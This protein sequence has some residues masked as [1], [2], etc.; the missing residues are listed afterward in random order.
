MIKTDTKKRDVQASVT[1]RRGANTLSAKAT[2]SQ[3]LRN[4]GML[5]QV[6][7]SE[8]VFFLETQHSCKNYIAL[9]TQK[10]TKGKTHVQLTLAANNK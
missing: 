3:S 4:K 8:S 9:D 2:V 1:K 6:E 10:S 7:G 5:I